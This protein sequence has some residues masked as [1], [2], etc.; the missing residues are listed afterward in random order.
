MEEAIKICP[1]CKQPVEATAKRCPTCGMSLHAPLSGN[2]LTGNRWLDVALGLIVGSVCMYGLWWFGPAVLR[3]SLGTFG[4]LAPL[5]GYFVF[6][7]KYP[8]FGRGILYSLVLFGIL[9]AVAI[10]IALGALV[11]CLVTAAKR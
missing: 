11:Y 1:N 7:N 4:L 6:R 8:A 10:A 3:T 9:C 5:A 2:R